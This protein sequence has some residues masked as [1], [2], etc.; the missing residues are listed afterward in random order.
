MINPVVTVDGVRRPKVGTLIDPGRTG[1]GGEPKVYEHVTVISAGNWCLSRVTGVDMAPLAGDAE[2]IDLFEQDYQNGEDA[3]TV[4]DLGWP[5]AKV[6][7]VRERLEI[8]GV[9]TSG[10]TGGT[11]LWRIVLDLARAV[12]PGL[13]RQM[14]AAHR[15]RGA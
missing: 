5:E 15:I 9:D 8:K 13:T 14:L 10:Y 1:P 2:C 3:R 12:E 6:S 7:R 4:S 11:P